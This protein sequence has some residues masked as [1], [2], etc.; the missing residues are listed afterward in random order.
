[1]TAPLPVVMPTTEDTTMT[2]TTDAQFDFRKCVAY[3]ADAKRRFHHQA[4]CRMLDL[5][6]ALGL[7]PD[8]YDLRSNQGGIAVSGEVTLHADRLYVQASQPGPERIP[9]SCSGPA[10]A[11]AITPL[12]ATITRRSI[13]CTSRTNSPR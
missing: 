13:C 3:D 5:A 12:A 7:E 11:G 1:M 9:A 6:D 8:E 10:R 4:R 2:D